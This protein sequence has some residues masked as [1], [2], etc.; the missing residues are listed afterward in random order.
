M[1]CPQHNPVFVIR[2]NRALSKL[3]RL[4]LGLLGESNTGNSA[5]QTTGAGDIPSHC[6]RP[7]TDRRRPVARE[8]ACH[9]QRFRCNH[10]RHT[11]CLHLRVMEPTLFG[12][13][14]TYFKSNETYFRRNGT[15]LKSNGTYFMSNGTYIKEK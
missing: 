7:L 5:F 4:S 11:R 15:Y 6:L 14:G 1:S 8:W 13:N 10:L 12:S 2:C 9:E 3:C